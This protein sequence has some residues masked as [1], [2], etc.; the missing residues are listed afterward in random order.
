MEDQIKVK[1]NILRMGF[2]IAIIMTILAIVTFGIAICTP[3]V[4]G[5]FCKGSCIMYPYNA[6]I[7]RFPRDYLWMY[8]A[9]LLSIIFIAFIVCIHY[10]ASD[11]KK[12][13]SLLSLSFALVSA[14][15][16]M[17]D[18]FIQVSVIQPSLVNG[19]TEGIAV[20][21]MYNPHGVFIAL[22]EIGNTL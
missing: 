22:E 15:V 14:I 19:E 8:P 4:S 20:L 6:I 12:I 3:P 10:Y 11:N 2:Y 16:L 18:Y 9:I 1:G 7:S 5:P 17:T 21:T 13:F